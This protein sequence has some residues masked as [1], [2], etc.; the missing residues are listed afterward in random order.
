MS[1]ICNIPMVIKH[2]CQRQGLVMWQ[3][4]GEQKHLQVG[5]PE[6]KSPPGRPR[7]RRHYNIE[8]VVQGGGWED[9]EWTDESLEIFK[10]R[11][12]VNAVLK[13]LVSPI[14]DNSL[15]SSGNVRCWRMTPLHAVCQWISYKI[16]LIIYGD[17]KWYWMKM[18]EYFMNN[19]TPGTF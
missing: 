4:R 15:T 13:L 19:D 17:I 2:I 14:E 11:A 8:M 6:W 10:G 7:C 9:L 1:F 16:V 18:V 3:L 5:K 12:I